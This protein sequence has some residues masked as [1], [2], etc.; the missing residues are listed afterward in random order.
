VE[1][2]LAGRPAWR[3]AA[4]CGWVL[5]LA[6]SAAFNF[7]ASSEIKLGYLINAEITFANAGRVDEAIALYR[8]ALEGKQVHTEAY[9]ILGNALFQKGRLD[10]AITQYQENLRLRPDDAVGHNNLG[11]A[12][13][14]KGRMDEAIAQYQQALQINPGLVPGHYNL[15]N[16][17]LQ[18]GKMDDAITQF[19]QVVQ[20]NPDI[21]QAHHTL[22]LALAQ[23]GR[24]DEAITH[25]QKTL[26]I[27]PDSADTLQILG[28]VLVQRGRV[29]EAI[30]QYQ[31]A[32]EI[33]PADPAVQINLAWLLATA[34]QA[35]LR[36]GGKAVE[37]A[38][39]ASSLTG[40]ENP[41][42]LHSLAAACAE[43]GR[44]SEAVETAQ[45]ALRLAQ[46]QT[47]AALAGA[48]QSELKLYQ[49]GSPLHSPEHTP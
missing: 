8:K 29:A 17:L 28:S 49:A 10:E 7:F 47:N 40:G 3:W 48:L 9:N 24:L 31:K 37:L 45:H 22:G 21:A 16:A 18:V 20:I 41:V 15:G 43:A 1:R 33:N 13:A 32:L 2:A 26:E 23:K 30:T 42:V 6:F 39:Q 27:K 44:F 5:L 38:R 12:L 14:Q 25:F 46:A 11:N 35:S 34:P 36:N 4:R 19:Q